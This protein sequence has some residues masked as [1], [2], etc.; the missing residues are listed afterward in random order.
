MATIW[1]N[2]GPYDIFF[3][4]IYITLIYLIENEMYLS[5]I[6]EV[7]SFSLFVSLKSLTNQNKYVVDIT[8]SD[9]YFFRNVYRYIFLIR[10]DNYFRT[11]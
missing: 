8:R 10:T 9:I 6:T 5:T 3:M 11:N 2:K 4:V 7:L 1:T